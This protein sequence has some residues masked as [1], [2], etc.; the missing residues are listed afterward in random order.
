[1]DVKCKMLLL[2]NCIN[3]DDGEWFCDD[4]DRGWFCDDDDRGEM[5]MMMIIMN[6][7]WWQ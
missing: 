1:M 7:K 5:M 2:I 4:E 6:V 3:Y